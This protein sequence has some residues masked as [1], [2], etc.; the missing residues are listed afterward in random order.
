MNKGPIIAGHEV[1][2]PLQI[3]GTWA[4]VH[5]STQEDAL[6]RLKDDPFTVGEVWDWSKAQV[7]SVIS[8]LRVPL[9]NSRFQ[10]IA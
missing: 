10:N 4:L 7:F 5:A 3:K 1:R 6:N 9:Q 2:T 8:G